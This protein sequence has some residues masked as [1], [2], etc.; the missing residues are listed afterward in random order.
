ML[1]GRDRLS[2][3]AKI[4]TESETYLMKAFSNELEAWLKDA[5]PKTLESLIEFAGEESF[6]IIILFLMLIPAL[7]VPIPG[8]SHVCEIITIVLALEMIF[9]V[10]NILLPRRVQ[11]IKI[12]KIV[13]GKALPV[14]LKRIRWFEKRSSPRGR[15]IFSLPLANRVIG[16]EILLLTIVAFFAPPF[17]G[18][19]TLPSLG[20]VVICLALILD[21]A[22]LLLA[23]TVVG[24]IG[25]VLLIGLGTLI[26]D[27]VHH[28]L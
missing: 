3:R 12:G 20:A 14:I 13:K 7:P 15:Y 25:A 26:V 6:A 23:G 11:Q 16:L 27:G 1:Y 10:K 17:S 18:L 19:D 2:S 9:G 21:D 4:E 28:V 22:L 24:S 8:L 5:Q